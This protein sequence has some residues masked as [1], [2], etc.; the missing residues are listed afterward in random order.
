MLNLA[1]ELSMAEKRHLNQF[2][3][4]V[5]VWCGK[6]IRFNRVCRTF[7]ELSLGSTHGVPSELDVAPVL[8]QSQTY[9]IR[10][11]T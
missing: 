6:S 9:S 7:V 3:I 4:A 11:G 8:F 5:L 10:F 1:D 2:G